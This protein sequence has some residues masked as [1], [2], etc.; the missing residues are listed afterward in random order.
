MLK[1]MLDTCICIY[2]IKN[3][4]QRVREAFLL[5]H[6][7]LCISTVTLMELIK[8]AEKSG[9]PES[10][11]KIIEGFVARLEVLDFDSKAAVHAG[12]IIAEL[13]RGGLRIGSYDNQ[14]AGHA[15][16]QGLII[17]TNNVREFE[18]VPGLRVEN[19]VNEK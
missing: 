1:Y 18:R 16:S 8:G 4:P 9:N 13:E 15:R 12:Q 7:Q 11:M 19:W 3:Q 6:D 10:N 2:T 14:I 17:V 5:H